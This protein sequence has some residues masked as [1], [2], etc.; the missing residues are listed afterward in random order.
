MSGKISK[1]YGVSFGYDFE[2]K[3]NRK[4]RFWGFEV[5][6]VL[7]LQRQRILAQKLCSLPWVLRGEL[8]KNFMLIFRYNFGRSRSKKEINFGVESESSTL[9]FK[10]YISNPNSQFYWVVGSIISCGDLLCI[11]CKV[12]KSFKLIIFIFRPRLA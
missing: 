1:F 2:W 10:R 8:T 3:I 4:T 6:S 11:W 7:G 5:S 9:G 12:C